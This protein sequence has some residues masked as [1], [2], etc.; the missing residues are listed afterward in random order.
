MISLN[1]L[2]YYLF[3]TE[4]LLKKI[5]WDEFKIYRIKWEFSKF[6]TI[7]TTLRLRDIDGIN[8]YFTQKASNFYG[9]SLVKLIGQESILG[10]HIDKLFSV[11]GILNKMMLLSHMY[12]LIH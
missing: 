9:L 3:L 10:D 5:K 6:N 7:K 2:F 8:Y 11:S 4:I 1:S 12:L